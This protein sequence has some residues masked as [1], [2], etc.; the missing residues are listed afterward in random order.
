MMKLG[1]FFV[2]T[3]VGSLSF[4]NGSFIEKTSVY[5]DYVN[6]LGHSLPSVARR[7]NCESLQLDLRTKSPR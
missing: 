4:V 5:C 1:F 7:L 3:I 2:G 6:P